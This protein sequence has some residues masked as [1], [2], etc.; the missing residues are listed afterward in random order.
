M[1]PTGGEIWRPGNLTGPLVCGVDEAGRGP[2]AG[3][4]VAAAVILSSEFETEGLQDSKK[5][6]PLGRI[7]EEKRIKQSACFW[8]IGIVEPEIVDRINILQASLLAMRRAIEKLPM[9]PGLVLVDG[10]NVIPELG[11]NQKAIVDGDALVPVISAASII[12]KTHR[13]RIMERLNLDYP[14]YGLDRHKG[15]PTKYHIEMLKRLG[16]SPIHRK[17][18]YPVSTFYE[19]VN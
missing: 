3:P 1:I 8:S 11:I 17:T 14:G 2:L 12:A 6:S 10:R 18:F 19:R 7:R 16:P 13:D 9:R 5:L 15:Y 4:V